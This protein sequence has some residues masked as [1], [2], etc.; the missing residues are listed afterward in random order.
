M[1]GSAPA[2]F[3]SQVLRALA[4]AA[5]RWFAGATDGAT[6]RTVLARWAH[7][8]RFDLDVQEQARLRALGR[9]LRADRG[10]LA[11]AL[12]TPAARSAPL[13]HRLYSLSAPPSTRAAPARR[14]GGRHALYRLFRQCDDE[15]LVAWAARHCAR[16]LQLAPQMARGG[17]RAA[18]I[19]ALLLERID[20]F[21]AV[22]RPLNRQLYAYRDLAAMPDDLAAITEKFLL[23]SVAWERRRRQDC[24][25]E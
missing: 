6:A 16:D 13:E 18:R 14:A 20:A 1:T 12:N 2:T 21:V 17:D 3:Q 19:E 9:R 7:A 23:A 4:H 25:A 15:A 24:R 22:G 8:Q 5:A 11:L 10:L